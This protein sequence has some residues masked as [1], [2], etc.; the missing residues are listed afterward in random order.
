[1]IFQKIGRV[2]QAALSWLGLIVTLASLYISPRWYVWVLAVVHILFFFMFR[3]L[4]VPPKVKSWGIVYDAATKKPIGRAV[5]RLFNSEFN[6]LVSTQVTDGSGRYYFLASDDKYYVTYDH[7]E[8]KQEKTGVLDLTGQKTDHI[9]VD[10]GLVKGQDEPRAPL[11]PS[12]PVVTPAP[13]VPPPATNQKLPEAPP[14]APVV[15]ETASAVATPI[16]LNNPPEPTPEAVVSHIDLANPPEPSAPNS[17]PH[18]D[19]ANPPE[20]GEEKKAP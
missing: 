19:L 14:S 2:F 18:I 10:I 8:Y 3:R 4:A 20:P 6:K 12:A 16:D 1:L 17:L 7:P 11:A 15:S 13:E 9:A 5:A